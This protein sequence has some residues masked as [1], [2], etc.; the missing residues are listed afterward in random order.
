MP[1]PSNRVIGID[2]INPFEDVTYINLLILNTNIIPNDIASTLTPNNRLIFTIYGRIVE[3]NDPVMYN[4]T[5][6]SG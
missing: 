6:N 2:T 5:S 1:L 4:E 3:Y